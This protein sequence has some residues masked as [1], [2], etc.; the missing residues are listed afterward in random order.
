[1]QGKEPTRD[2]KLAILAGTQHGVVAY[3]QLIAMAFTP[4][5][6]EH[7]LL[8]GRLHR[9]YK[10]VYSVGYPAKTAEAREMAAVLRCGRKAVVS[11]WTAASR[12]Q[13]LRPTRGPVHVSVPSDRRVKGIRTHHVNRFDA[14][15]CTKR[16]GIPITSV[17]RTLLDLAAVADHRLLKRAANEA[18]RAGRLNRKAVEQLMSRNP[19]RKGTRRLRAVIAAVHPGTRRSRSDLETG[20]LEL[21]SEYELPE[22]RVNAEV[23]GFEVDMHWPGTR[24]I[25]ELDTYEYHRTPAEFER[26]RLRDARLKLAGYEVL[27]ITGGWLGSDSAGVAETVRA[28]LSRPV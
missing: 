11:H 9:V 25:V 22:P 10:G 17:P 20:F 24:L 18:E 16:D 3:P 27:R 8:T 1:M 5:A 14:G 26:D 15:D 6:I 2:A 28:L 12:W 23:E 19:R 7:R 4:G 13:L 21:L